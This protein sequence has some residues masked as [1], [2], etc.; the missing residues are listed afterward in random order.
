MVIFSIESV[1]MLR[2]LFLTLLDTI[3]YYE[4]GITKIQQISHSG[5]ERYSDVQKVMNTDTGFRIQL[6]KQFV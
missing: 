5:W 6:Y 2:Y 4:N 3:L 1:N